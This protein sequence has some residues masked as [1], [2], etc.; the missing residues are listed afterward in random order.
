VERRAG[1]ARLDA[2][3]ARPRAPIKGLAADRATG[4]GPGAPARRVEGLAA[5]RATGIGPGAAARHVEGRGTSAASSALRFAVERLAE[6]AGLDAG[7]ARHP[8]RH[9]RPKR[10][11]R[12]A[13]GGYFGSHAKPEDCGRT[14]RRLIRRRKI[15]AARHC[16]PDRLPSDRKAAAMSDAIWDFGVGSGPCVNDEGRYY[17]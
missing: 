3:A 7:A 6:L 4:I 1:V 16:G 14:R 5:D 8:C 12:T 9:S 10:Q 2:G 13:G 11:R 15:V 17:A